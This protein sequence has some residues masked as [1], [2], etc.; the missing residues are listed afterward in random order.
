[1]CLS[2]AFFLSLTLSSSSCSVPSTP[3][4]GT[5]SAASDTVVSPVAEEGA[6]A[7][8]GAA[9]EV[10]RISG[11]EVACEMKTRQDL[12]QVNRLVKALL[13]LHS[14][15]FLLQRGFALYICTVCMWIA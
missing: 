4:L 10:R 6:G 8:G 13:F 2:V 7:E 14:C 12:A 15:F 1:M 9:S 11:R 5:S 3:Y